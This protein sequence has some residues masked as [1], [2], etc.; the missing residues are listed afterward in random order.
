VGL[1]GFCLRP[2]CIVTE[3]VEAGSLYEF[4]VDDSKSANLQWPLRLKI[5]K[6]IGNPQS[7]PHLMSCW[8]CG[9]DNHR[10]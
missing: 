6:D 8:M 2:A 3:L 9:V 7:F 4:L 1:K 5:A 10:T